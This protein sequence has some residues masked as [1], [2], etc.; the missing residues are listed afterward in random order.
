MILVEPC[1]E[2]KNEYIKFVKE[3]RKN[4]EVESSYT[5]EISFLKNSFHE[6]LA[7][8]EFIS[9][10]PR[11]EVLIPMKHYWAVEG[12]KIVGRVTIRSNSGEKLFRYIGNIGY[13]IAPNSRKN[14]YGSKM[15]ELAK[16]KAKELGYEE[17]LIT[18]S[19]NNTA[20]KKIIEKNGGVFIEE[21]HWE[22]KG[23]DN[24]SY[25][26]YLNEKSSTEL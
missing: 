4:N 22:E 24:L 12:K 19:K 14:G 10:Y 1:I 18:C 5:L 6:F 8:L 20:S 7:Y 17:I 16:V 3:I 11:G 13:I 21:Y 15:L 25:K 26:I 23:L 9:K 2:Y